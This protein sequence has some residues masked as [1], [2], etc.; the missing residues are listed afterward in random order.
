MFDE[1]GAKHGI[2]ATNFD[3]VYNWVLCG[4]R[5][6]PLVGI[7]EFFM[8]R[9]MQ[10]F[11]K[12]ARQR[13]RFWGTLKWCCTRMTECLETAQG[14]ALLH[15]VISQ[16]LHQSAE[17]ENMWRYE[18]EFKGK[19]R[20]VPSHEKT[21]QVCELGNQICRCSHRKPQLLHTPC[22]HVIAVCYELQNFSYRRYVHWYYEKET[23]Q[24]T[25]NWTIEGY[26]A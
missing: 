20:L 18:V 24:N 10:Y 2:K 22:S 23:V 21:Q 9:T 12:G 7:I 13:M 15:K 26:L 11:T 3:E 5:P 14:K 1:G 6:L 8:Y 25:W 17:N 16:S 4:S 19:M